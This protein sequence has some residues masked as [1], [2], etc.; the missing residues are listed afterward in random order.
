M[1]KPEPLPPP[2]ILASQPGSWTL[3]DGNLV[4]TPDPEVASSTSPAAPGA[5]LVVPSATNGSPN[6]SPDSPDI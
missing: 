6:V 5:L 1:K 4:P 2:P 3:I